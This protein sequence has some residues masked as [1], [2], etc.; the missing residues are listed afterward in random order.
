VAVPESTD[1]QAAIACILDTVDTTIERTRAAFEWAKLLRRALLAELLSH[2][3]DA[4][5]KVRRTGPRHQGFCK[6]KIGWLPSEWQLSSIGSEFELQNGFTLDEDRRP[7]LRKRRY[8]RVANVQRDVLKLGDVLELEAKDHEFAPRRLE[9]EDLLVV[10]GHADR[11]QI[12][13][14]A[15][16]TDA[17]VGMTFQNHLFRLRTRGS[18]VPAFACL[19]LNSTYAQRYWNACCATSSGLNTINQRMLKRLSIPVFSKEEQQSICECVQAQRSHLEALAAKGAA[20]DHLKE[21]LMH[22]L[23]TGK[24]RVNIKQL[25][26]LLKS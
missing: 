17:A 23:L 14:C 26:P 7:K 18:L 10:E 9:K 11:M 6:T 19:W 16:V 20:L 22:D 1:E 5:G 8:L 24:V 21:S 13:R 15:R 25:E 2:G 4:R 3:V 12:G